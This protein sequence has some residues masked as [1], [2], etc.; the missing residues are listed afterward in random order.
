MPRVK[1]T[2]L[3]LVALSLG[4]LLESGR[5]QA[6]VQLLK[7]QFEMCH[8][9]QQAEQLL[10]LL[11]RLPDCFSQDLAA[12]QLYLQTLC[13]ARKPQRILEWFESNPGDAGLQVYRAWALARAGRYTEALEVLE[14]VLPERDGGIFYRTKGEALFWLNDPN[15]QGVLEQSRSYLQGAALGRMLIDL[16]GFLNVRGQRAAA[17]VC[18]AEALSY[19]ADDP[20]Y[21]AWTHNSI[22]YALLKDQPVEAERHLLEAV[23]I[24]KK[25]GAKAFRSKALAGLG[26]FRRSMG[27]LERA[28]HSYQQAFRAGGDGKDPQ[29]ALWGW[30]HI[31]RLLGRLEEAL[32]KLQQA[33]RL[34]PAEVWLEADLAASHLML[35]ERERVEQSLSRLHGYLGS[36][37]LGERT[38]VV[39]RVVE[40]ELARQDGDAERALNLLNGMC[41]ESLWVR[42]E[43]GCFPSLAQMIGVLSPPRGRSYCVDV[44]PFGC[45]EVRVNGRA[46][47]LPAVSKAGE[48]LVF[49]LVNGQKASLEV[50]LDRLGDPRN[51]NPRKALWG[52]IEKLRQALGWQDSVQSCGGAYILDPEAQWICDLDPSSHLSVA[53]NDPSQTFMEGYYSEWVV[54]WRQQWLVV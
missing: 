51:K 50:L 6:A 17:R 19:L 38:Q 25:E 26:A 18:W 22:G 52:V 47:P 11:E 41:P 39:L 27:E 24:S 7:S 36:K 12:Q 3:Q 45:L 16:G 49:L 54:E 1:P 8:T 53:G 35:G 43:L 29:L 40:A 48:L 13:R 28:L 44:K 5:T 15:W 9:H 4:G 10:G 34:N 32:A 14:G 37:Q 31:L 20:Y 23:R 30:G 33:L 2:D 46:V 42:E 21:L